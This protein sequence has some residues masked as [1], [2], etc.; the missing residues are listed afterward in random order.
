MGIAVPDLQED[1]G[2]K[3]SIRRR[4]LLALEGKPDVTFSMVE[5]PDLTVEDL[6][7]CQTPYFF[8]IQLTCFPPPAS[9]PAFPLG[10]GLP[11]GLSKR[12]SLGRFA[13]TLPSKD[14]LGTLVEED[15][16]ESHEADNGVFMDSKTTASRNRPAGLNLRPL[17]LV[18]S[19]AATSP[20]SLPTPTS[21]PTM[22][23]STA[24]P[25][26][27]SARR[28]LR[29]LSLSLSSSDG[30]SQGDMVETPT[31]A[32]QARRRS[33]A[34]SSSPSPQ[35]SVPS[36]PG[37]QQRRPSLNVDTDGVANSSSGFKPTPKRRSSIQYKKTSD[38]GVSG[39]GGVGLPTPNQ[40]PVTSRAASSAKQE[41]AALTA[42][43]QHFLFQSHQTLLTRITDLE[44]V[45]RTK[46]S[47]HYPRSVSTASDYSTQSASDTCISVDVPEQSEEMAQV[48]SDLREERDELK[49][50]VDGWRVRVA[51]LE[52]QIVIL[53]Q[54][55]ESERRDT[56]TAWTKMSEVEAD[57]NQL[58]KTLLQRDGEVRQAEQDYETLHELLLTEE[59]SR[60]AAENEA[61]R[62]REELDE[63]KR[64]LAHQVSLT[65]LAQQVPSH[66][67]EG[68]DEDDLAHYEDEH[69]FDV[70]FGSMGTSS[71]GDF[72]NSIVRMPLRLP[73]TPSLD[74]S[75]MSRSPSPPHEQHGRKVSLSKWV[76]PAGPSTPVRR[77]SEDLDNFFGLDDVDGSPRANAS[78]QESQ[79]LFTQSLRFGSADEDGEDD[80]MPPFVLPAHVGTEV[81]TRQVLNAVIEEEEEEED[82]YSREETLVES[83]VDNLLRE[84]FEAMDLAG[85]EHDGVMHF[86][87][88]PNISVM[89]TPPSTS[90][91]P[92]KA[93]AKPTHNEEDDF[94]E[95]DA[96]K[97]AA[98]LSRAKALPS[99]PQR[100]TGIKLPTLPSMIPKRTSPTASPT[101]PK[102]AA[103]SRIPMRSPTSPRLAMN[104]GSGFTL[105][106]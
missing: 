16:D 34:L 103:T 79:S 32:R 69:E 8:A 62:L 17:A 1:S 78:N 89:V 12:D 35:A 86:T 28:G 68:D 20:W 6:R 15:E 3:D 38:D 58:R 43:E 84:D 9:Q 29:S 40:T 19:T 26:P 96:I 55:V 57:R 104:H 46:S 75:E 41:P 70:S 105:S 80:D 99:I 13:N 73:Q 66:F 82:E 100:K 61:V 44:R 25:S 106:R 91:T 23:P 45:L 14:Q 47:R 59:K 39:E 24:V 102:S 2:D 81:L 11:S 18:S 60:C 10:A 56:W 27:K 95:A 51:D 31:T 72:T 97:Q 7:T 92:M 101:R 63:Q 52:R 94:F 49:R 90:T 87:F 50:D 88:T 48:V 21:T 98:V 65:Q 74:L 36:P 42:S 93:A 54:C 67:E 4:A 83:P 76:F 33:L 30:I 37:F 53:N 5:I 85:E 64:L 71:S 77:S 22:T